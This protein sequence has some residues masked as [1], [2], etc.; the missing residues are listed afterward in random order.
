[1]YRQEEVY[2]KIVAHQYQEVPE[3]V[4]EH[5]F[6]LF[7]DAHSLPMASI[8]VEVKLPKM[9]AGGLFILSEYDRIS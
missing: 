8:L 4:L 3:C 1:M 6:S 9:L 2:E 5:L 7:L